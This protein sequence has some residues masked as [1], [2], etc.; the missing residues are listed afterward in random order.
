MYRDI[1]NSSA[2]G[3]HLRRNRYGSH[4]FIDRAIQEENGLCVKRPDA[5]SFITP[6]VAQR[7]NAPGIRLACWY[8]HKSYIYNQRLDESRAEIAG[9]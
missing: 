3:A 6:P 8:T 5:R 2:Y 1:R 7:Y 9:S 4:P